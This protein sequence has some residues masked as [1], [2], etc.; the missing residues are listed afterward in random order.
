MNTVAKIQI[1]RVRLEKLREHVEHVGVGNC[2]RFEEE[3][4]KA[5]SELRSLGQTTEQ[6]S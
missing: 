6:P 3:I 5:E 1:L 2:P 4:A